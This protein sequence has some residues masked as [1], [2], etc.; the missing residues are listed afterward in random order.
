MGSGR[1]QLRN[2]FATGK[3]AMYIE[4]S[5]TIPTFLSAN[6]NLKFSLMPWPAVN[7]KD[8]RVT[9]FAGDF[10]I[11]Y[12]AT[13]KYPDIAK[14][15]L[16]FM[17]SKAAAQ[18]YAEKD[19][20]ISCVKGVEYV[21][22]QLKAQMDFI[23]AGGGIKTPDVIWTTRQQDAVGVAYQGLYVSKDVEKFC[24]DLQNVWNNM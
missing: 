13:A 17:T 19:G 3:A 14:K 1:D 10:G 8:T 18:Y 5:W 6:P 4:G 15:F 20:S 11:S 12:S 21:A 7:A 23:N 9:A 24:Q 16:T 22:P 2:D